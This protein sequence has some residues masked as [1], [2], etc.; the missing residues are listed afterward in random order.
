MSSFHKVITEMRKIVLFHMKMEMILTFV[1]CLNIKSR[2]F[3]NLSQ[4]VNWYE[5]FVWIS[6]HVYG[7]E[8]SVSPFWGNEEEWRLNW[9]CKS[10][11]YWT[12]IS[13]FVL[14]SWDSK[15]IFSHLSFVKKYD[16]VFY[17]YQI[18]EKK[19]GGKQRKIEERERKCREREKN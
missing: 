16:V 1:Q 10:S 7:I 17:T 11:K 2:F 5:H 14:K 19:R 4:K 15:S 6:K 12:W 3:A 8:K 13:G 9:F 18:N